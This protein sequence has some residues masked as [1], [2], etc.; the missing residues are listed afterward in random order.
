[1]TKAQRKVVITEDRN[2]LEAA[3]AKTSVVHAF[4]ADPDD[5][6]E[7]P[8]HAYADIAPLLRVSLT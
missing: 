3:K 4:D 5:H 7:T 1:M 8:P 2:A 6:C